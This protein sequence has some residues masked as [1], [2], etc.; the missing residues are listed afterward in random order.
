[1]HLEQASIEAEQRELRMAEERRVAEKEL[2]T[3]AEE[4]AA[5]LRRESNMDAARESER[6]ERERHVFNLSSLG[7]SYSRILFWVM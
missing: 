1:M 5:R 6:L 4:E 2:R 7:E 3:I